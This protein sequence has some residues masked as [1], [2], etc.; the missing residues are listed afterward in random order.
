MPFTLQGFCQI[1]FDLIMCIPQS[2]III[3]A[4]ALIMMISVPKRP[5]SGTTS[6]IFI[7]NRSD[8]IVKYNTI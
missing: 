1:N 3:L 2:Q 8:I 4:R 6:N 5:S 7:N